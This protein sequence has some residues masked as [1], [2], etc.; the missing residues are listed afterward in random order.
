MTGSTSQRPLTIAD[1]VANPT[2]RSYLK[3]VRDWHGYIRFLGLPDRRDNPDVL[4]DRLFVEPLLARRHV[5][6]DEDP[7]GWLSDAE[8]VFE[9]LRV[10]TR[11]VLLG[12]PGSG[13]S[14]LL[15][16]LVWLLARPTGKLW[17]TQMGEWLLPLP[18]VLRDLNLR[19]VRDFGGLLHAFL[20]HTMSE[21]LRRGGYLNKM[22]NRG[23]ALILVDGID[24]I[25]DPKARKDLRDAVLDGFRRYQECRWLLTSRVVGYDELPFS[26]DER[27]QAD[28]PILGTS[29]VED[30]K[31][32]RQVK[33]SR[34][35]TKSS[36]SILPKA[37]QGF[38]HGPTVRYVAPFDDR[39]IQAFAYNWYAQREAAATRAGEDAM[40]LVR[41]VHADDAILRLARVPNLLTLMALI[42]RIEAILPHGRALLYD[43]ISE[44]YLESIDRYRGIYSGA[45]NLPKKKRWLARIAFEL[46]KERSLH[47]IGDKRNSESEL[48]VKAQYVVFW[49]NDEMQHDT[50]T[51]GWTADEFLSF[52][53]R[54]SG[55]F[56]PR[57]QGRYAFVH[58]SFQEYFSALALEREVTSLKWARNQATKLNV[59]RNIVA[60][61]ATQSVWRDTF[62]FLFELLSSKNDW[63]A[64][65]LEVV[66]GENFSS[67]RLSNDHIR[68]RTVMNLAY[69]LSILVVNQYSG[70]AETNRNFAIA[71][72]VRS[73]IQ[74]RTMA[75]D[76]EN[77]AN[78]IDT[79]MASEILNK[80]L[81]D[82]SNRKTK[83]L[84]VIAEQSVRLQ[85]KSLN[86]ARVQISDLHFLDNLNALEHLD[87][88]ETRVSDIAPLRHLTNL[89]S[90]DLSGT[91]ITDLEPAADFVKLQSLKL[92]K[93]RVADLAPLAGLTKLRKLH[94]FGTAVS[95][96]APLAD[97]TELRGLDLCGTA[98][99]DLGPL[100][101]LTELLG[102]VLGDTWVTDLG[103]VAG[104]TQL[105]D[106][107]LR[108]MEF[109]DLGLLANLTE[110]RYLDLCATMVA[111]LGPLANLTK[112]RRLNL[113][114]TMVSDVGPL[115]NLTDLQFLSLEKT[116]VA[117]LRPL[118]NHTNLRELELVDTKVSDFRL[119]ASF[120][121]LQFLSLG[122]SNVSKSLIRTLRDALPL[123]RI[124]HSFY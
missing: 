96:L 80:L 77:D 62:S 45:Y 107:G 48:L 120:S 34:L 84:Q 97:L 108:G 49:L 23:K 99:S 101:G 85:I 56:L 13:K 37:G 31:Q 68:Y 59:D 12:D 39:R 21:P 111:D 74:H 41:A 118:V 88:G 22:L 36:V 116:S 98:V 91:N 2:L 57:G 47:L 30:W 83:C 50:D 106:L 73:A 1:L 29:H 102:L 7:K 54:R 42:H 10:N 69:L 11:I 32:S 78:K 40:H 95:D 123:C 35:L 18:I 43:R 122:G 82:D 103:P 113:C 38:D 79:L 67:L 115:A 16:Y 90:L 104:L 70:L 76:F 44:A 100:S 5:S 71:A 46:Q 60:E 65:L 55:L 61:W 72:I 105:R 8:T 6:P 89:R 14:T 24:E 121:G 26:L 124:F 33:G 28:L 63:H 51:D 4:I 81:G 20:D 52:V 93:T 94:L 119:V 92:G 64:D 86:L 9:A 117:D 110:L 75:E 53:G 58:L 66:F 15:N 27:K 19:G 17:T 109:S 3:N 25:G 87:L 114:A 112:L